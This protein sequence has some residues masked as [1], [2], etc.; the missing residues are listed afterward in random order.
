MGSFFCLPFN[1]FKC[2]P[3]KKL[4]FQNVKQAKCNQSLPFSNRVLI[5]YREKLVLQNEKLYVYPL[6]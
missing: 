3:F 6:V 4:C 2:I 5:I 1:K